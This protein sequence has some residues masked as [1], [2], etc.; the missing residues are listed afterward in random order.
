MTDTELREID[1]Q[2]HREVMGAVWDETRCRVCGWPIVP[3]GLQGCW[4][5]SC[6][7]RPV[8]DRRAD[9][10]PRYSSSIAAAWQIVE[11]LTGWEYVKVLIYESH[12]HGTTCRVTAPDPTQRQDGCP[13][14]RDGDSLGVPESCV[15]AP[16][17]IC[18]AALKAVSPKE[19]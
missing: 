8:P 10:P 16:L 2:V 12:Y 1:A 7:M 14:I 17:A 4:A 5:R 6:A 9:E 11:K 19:T 15:S 3:T 18:L 13:V